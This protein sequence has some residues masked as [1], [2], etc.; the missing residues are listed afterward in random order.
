MKNMKINTVKQ[1]SPQKYMIQN[2]LDRKRNDKIMNLM[3]K[4]SISDEEIDD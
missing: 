1:K 4:Y 3:N 2:I